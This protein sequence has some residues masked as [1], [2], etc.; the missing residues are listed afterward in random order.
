[1]TLRRLLGFDN[2][3]EQY[4]Y[5]QDPVLGYTSARR[6]AEKWVRSTCGYC[7]VGCGMELG[8]R[9]NQI[10]AVRGDAQ[11]PV[12]IGKLCPKGL[13]EHQ[14]VHASSRA[15][16]PLLKQ[17]GEQQRVNW[18]TALNT[19]VSRFRD[20]QQRHGQGAV[21]VISTGQLLTEEFY[22][23][24][25]L[26]QLGFRTNNY[27]GNTTLCMASAVSGYKRSLGSDGPPG[28]YA[29]MREAEVVF[30]IGANIA[31]NHPILCQHLEAN[32]HGK[33]IV[34]DPRIS[35]T[36]MMADVML[37]LKP[38][39]D[40]ALMNGIAHILIRDGRIDQKYIDAHTSGWEA[41]RA[42]ALTWA[43]ERTSIVTGL[44]VEQIET[45]ARMI[46]HAKSAFYAWTMGVN[47][48]TQ[49][50]ETVSAIIN[51]SLMTGQI[52]RAGSAPFSITGQC[53]AMGS[54]ETAFTRGMPGYRKYDD[55]VHRAE[56]ASLWGMSEADL[57]AAA[58]YAYPDIIEAAARGEV[59]AIWFI[60][61]N[62]VVSFPN[63]TLLRLCQSRI[64]RRA[65]WL[66]SD[67][68]RGTG[69]SRFARRH[70]GRK[71]RLLYELGA[72][73][74]QSQRR[75]TAAG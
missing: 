10:V 73:R 7:S 33:V 56:L 42:Y 32:R 51:L 29:D 27:D 19:M 34:A 55:A 15:L 74:F 28:S 6:S 17:N 67:A 57:P 61:T 3:R 11:H 64:P 52:G 13:A 54:R 60:A 72:A 63:Q 16:Y 37:P 47:H 59:K 9:D 20:I 30:L 31:D 23:L 70:L 58:G 36:A 53:N 49:G 71:R 69:G 50:A 35:K 8:V 41:F 62:P 38:R 68:H 43:P 46:G 2:L 26:V 39:T 12:N 25:K 75:R 65:G 5:A 45:T 14:M 40:I 4:R 22:A 48:S 44:S 1:M 66:P 18:G 21:A 24:G